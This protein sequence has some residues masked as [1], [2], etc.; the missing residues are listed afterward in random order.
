M[1]LAVTG[2]TPASAGNSSF[3]FLRLGTGS[4]PAALA[5][6][7][8]ASGADIT[9]AF[10]N[11]SLL[12]AFDGKNQVVFMHNS[13]FSDITENYLALASRGRQVAIGGYLILGRVEDFERRTGPDPEPS[14]TFDENNFVG[15]VTYARR[16]DNINVGLAFKYAYEKIDYASAGAVMFD[17]GLHTPLTDEISVGGAVKN[18]GTKPKFLIEAFEL[19]REIRI[20][21]AYKPNYF[22]RKLELLGDA[23]FYSDIDTKVNLGAEYAMGQYFNLRAGYGIGYDS[24]GISL[25]GGLFYRQF[26][27]DYAFVGYKNDLG[28]AHRFTLAATF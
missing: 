27:F 13:Y 2:I 25:G 24:R 15:A 4:R 7:V 9:S 1:A 16:F 8:T 3:T 11:P 28:N 26:K 18:I 14:G 5:E 21:F 17:F 6:A 12:N 10:Y 22:Q 20:G 23:A 19:P